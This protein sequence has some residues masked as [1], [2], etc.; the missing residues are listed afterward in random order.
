MKPKGII[1]LQTDQHRYDCMGITGHPLVQTPNMDR[2]AH[3]GMLFT[4]AHTQCPMCVPTRSSFLTGR[5]PT[6]TGVINNWDSESPHFLDPALPTCPRALK[7][8]GWTTDYIGR[9]HVQPQRTPI[10]YGFDTYLENCMVRNREWKYVWNATAEDELYHLPSD[11]YELKNRAT[12]ESCRAILSQLRI[13][14]VDWMEK[15]E[16]RLLNPLTRAQLLDGRKV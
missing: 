12:D 7:Q 15:T 11:P 9:W 4:Q 16:D 6:Q 8:A 5:W 1:F 3:E 10:D 2:L 14:L 13:R